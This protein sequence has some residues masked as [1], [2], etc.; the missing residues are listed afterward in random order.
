VLLQSPAKPEGHI[1][2]KSATFAMEFP[3]VEI[4][5][6][7]PAQEDAI[8]DEEELQ[9]INRPMMELGFSP[10]Q[11]KGMRTR[12]ISRRMP[13]FGN[14]ES[15]TPIDLGQT[16]VT[17]RALELM[18]ESPRIQS[19]RDSISSVGSNSPGS[20]SLP[21]R[22][23]ASPMEQESTSP[24]SPQAT[25]PPDK[26]SPYSTSHPRAIPT[27][28]TRPALV[29]NVNSP[30]VSSPGSPTHHSPRGR[31][32]GTNPS[33]INTSRSNSVNSLRQP[34]V[35]C[36]T[37]DTLVANLTTQADR[38][39]Y[40]DEF[41]MSP[42]QRSLHRSSTSGSSTSPSSPRISALALAPSIH[43]Q[44]SPLA[45]FVVSTGDMNQGMPMATTTPT[46]YV[47]QNQALVTTDKTGKI[48][49][50]NEVVLRTFQCQ[51]HEIIGGDALE[52]L[53][54]SYREKHGKLLQSQHDDSVLVC[55]KVVRILKKDKKTAAA[56]LWLKEKRTDSG[57]IIYMWVFEEIKEN[58]VTITISPS[59]KIISAN[60]AC[61]E[62]FGW[63][64]SELATK[65][66]WDLIPSLRPTG[67][68]DVEQVDRLK[69][70]GAVTRQGQAVPVICKV[71]ESRE[72]QVTLQIISMPNIAGM[73]TIS[74]NGLIQSCNT[75]FAKYLFGL[76]ARD[77]VGKVNITRLIPQLWTVIHQMQLM[78]G[79][80]PFLETPSAV[81]SVSPVGSS[82]QSP[83]ESVFPFT[84][85]APIPRTQIIAYH[86][87][88]TPFNIDLQPRSTVQGEEFV[89]TLWITYDRYAASKASIFAQH[90]EAAEKASNSPSSPMATEL[91]LPTEQGKKSIR[92]FQ[93]LETL[94]EGAYGF[95]KLAQLKGEKVV[96]KY[97]IKSRILADTWVRD[98]AMGLVPMEIHVLDYLRKHPHPC[99]VRMMDYFEDD[100]YYYI[101]QAIHGYGMDL[102]DYIEY[103][104]TMSE[105]EIKHIFH[106]VALAVNHL[107][108]RGIVHR[109]IKDEN[110]ILDEHNNVQ[111]IDFGSSAYSKE[112]RLFDTFCGTLDY[113]SPEV[114]TGHRYSGLPQDIWS[115][116]I[117]LY[118]MTYKENPFYNIDEIISRPLRIP[119][120]MSDDNINLIQF[121][122]NRDVKK[123]PTIVEVLR[124][125]W[126]ASRTMPSSP[127][128]NVVPQSRESVPSGLE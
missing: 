83:Q 64:E 8:S 96:I 50:A 74:E 53:A 21:R 89:Y 37:T 124:H 20:N 85:A 45:Q 34:A 92:D 67:D 22:T 91:T 95:V 107:H 115:L 3:S 31:H 62:L 44:G 48:L 60:G 114:L 80:T 33:A 39:Q 70:F 43:Q 77:L 49:T 75:V 109:D 126:L 86:R 63:E 112:G 88:G 2:T 41:K 120:V 117:L 57:T 18:R 73:M 113:A 36:A 123:R 72:T 26:P 55:G 51:R 52:F 110:L 24:D 81:G 82:S 10:M 11:V 100:E 102:F 66:L 19:R 46:R 90:S 6:L 111:L 28:S 29:R 119:W 121:M 25:S 94:G 99:I 122:L 84:P 118:T 101:Q 76:S 125:P 87:D 17:F 59:G 128:R 104:Q 127:P 27:L 105:V 79:V 69:F 23:E 56:S 61:V 15:S 5:T 4:S 106:Q 1:H 47:P 71:V 65:R 103:N 97:V 78:S 54:P 42:V 14:V 32:R 7:K 13:L 93:V 40:T 12:S 98:R 116:G 38:V 108:Q 9:S 68:F 58:S 35:H 16:I 30:I